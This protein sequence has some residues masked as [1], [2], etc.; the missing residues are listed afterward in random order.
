LK[1]S[2]TGTAAL[3]AL[4][5]LAC[6]L[7]VLGGCERGEGR[8]EPIQR[9]LA[10]GELRVATS[11]DFP[12]MTMRDR[13]GQ[14]MGFEVDLVQALAGTMNLKVSFVQ[15]PFAELIPSVESGKVDMALAGMT[16]TPERN[17]RVAFAGPYLIS[18]N[19]LL[20][21]KRELAEA[22][23]PAQ[24]DDAKLSFAA[25]ESSTSARFV[26]A[27]MPQ[28]K[29]VTV[30]DNES[31]VK[32]VLAGEV[33]G[34]VADL[35]VLSVARWRHP[36]TELYLRYAPFTT[37]PLGI[38]LPSD[39]P[40]YLNLVTNYLNTLEETGELAQLKAKWLGDGT[41]LARLP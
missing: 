5:A 37:E 19:T 10:S 11:G 35:Q 41:W 9:I 17:A 22:Q 33:D 40:L 36:D 24:L 12:P 20:T 27:H 39:A 6:A 13:E 16:I 14:L 34:M 3:T 8:Q 7:L 18:G 23:D 30:P 29:L 31:G 38:A 21:S 1:T 4:T 28:A 2:R 15:T 26:K 32:A 25:V